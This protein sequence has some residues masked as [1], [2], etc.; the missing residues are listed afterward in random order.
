MKRPAAELSHMETSS[1]ASPPRNGFAVYSRL[2]WQYSAA[3]R[4]S[5]TACRAA[6]DA[7]PDSSGKRRAREASRAGPCSS[8]GLP[9]G[10]GQTEYGH[11]WRPT[12][13]THSL[14]VRARRR[15]ARRPTAVT[16][17]LRVRARQRSGT[18]SSASPHSSPATLAL[19]RNS[20]A[21]ASQRDSDGRSDH[22]HPDH[23][24]A[25]TSA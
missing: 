3:H 24:T 1:F 25:A 17:S 21:R 18:A 7:C 19:P 10:V 2:M 22:L 6:S 20:R 23:R 12:G 13:A 15:S 16:H 5:L 8:V 11:A 4:S 9:V 14:R